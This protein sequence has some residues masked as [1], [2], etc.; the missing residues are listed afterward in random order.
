MKL[1][2]KDTNSFRLEI[3]HMGLA[4]WFQGKPLFNPSSYD[5]TNITSHWV[6][7]G[8]P[9][10]MQRPDGMEK[11]KF[12]IIKSKDSFNKFEPSFPK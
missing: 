7:S 9:V 10:H 5:Y 6:S 2:L 8:N 3:P 1:Y 12:M 4:G 11:S